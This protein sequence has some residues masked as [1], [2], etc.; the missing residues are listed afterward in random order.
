MIYYILLMVSIIF[1]DQ[2]TKWLAVICLKG[3]E[4]YPFWK[5]V[6]H[7]T[8]VENRGSA[9]GM[10][11]DHRWVFMSV[12]TVVIIA[13]LLIFFIYYKKLT[14]L[15]RWAISFLVAGGIGNIIDRVFLGYVV[16]F[17]DFTLID[18]AV[19]NVADSFVCIGAGLFILWYILDAI[20]E[21]KQ[22]KA[23]KTALAE[24]NG[25][26]VSVATEDV[27][28][29]EIKAEAESDDTVSD[30]E[31]NAETSEEA[32]NVSDEDVKSENSSVK[33]EASEEVA[34]AEDEKNEETSDTAP[35]S[36]GETT[37]SGKES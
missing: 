34:V 24:V 15:M 26:V 6:F 28:A 5:D 4:S 29:E 11:K 18:F 7:F 32:V 33:A 14:P 13:A 19:F 20:N 3:E 31:D 16:D 22:K 36:E 27:K 30:I 9:F 2:L 37:E 35:T 8:Y 23:E 1:A 17:L 10:L 12:S 21:Y 25:E